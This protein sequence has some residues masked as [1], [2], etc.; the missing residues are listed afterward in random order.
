MKCP[1]CD[2]ENFDFAFENMDCDDN[3]VMECRECG[4]Q[5]DISE[6]Q[7]LEEQ[8]TEKESNHDD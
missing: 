2:D 3:D 5:M 7:K 4:Y 6:W 1:L 8:A